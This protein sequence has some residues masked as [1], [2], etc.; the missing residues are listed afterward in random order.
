MLGYVVDIMRGLVQLLVGA[1]ILG[2]SGALQ[3]TY[4]NAR[5]D[6]IDHGHGFVSACLL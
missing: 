6:I 4:R 2:L 1:H 5:R 3:E